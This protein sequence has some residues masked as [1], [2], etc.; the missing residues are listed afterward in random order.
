ML[1]RL[2][3]QARAVGDGKEVLEH[4]IRNPYDLILMDIQMPGMDGFE[5]THAIRTSRSAYRRIPIIA[6][7]ANAMKGDDE[8]CLEAGMDDYIAKPI[9]AGMLQEK[10]RRW[11][12]RARQAL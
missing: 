11:T 2:G 3:Y 5:A 8:K 10:L 12:G 4:L 9:D 6:M 1:D 7:T